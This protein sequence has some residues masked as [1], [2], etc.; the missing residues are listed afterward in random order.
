MNGDPLTITVKAPGPLMNMND[1]HHWRVR[2]PAA[3]AWRLAAFIAAT[4]GD[5]HDF[6]PS[7]VQL[8]LPVADKRRRDPHNY[9]PTVKHVIDGLVDAGVWPDDTPEWVTTIEPLLRVD[10][11]GPVLVHIWPRA[12]A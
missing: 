7:W 2:G 12:A 6:Y 11:G 10:R 5:H 8:S 9:A 1:H 3:K 4:N